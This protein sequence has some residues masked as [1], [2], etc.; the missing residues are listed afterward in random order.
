ME[1]DHPL[2][3]AFL[4]LISSDREKKQQ[5]RMCK[6]FQCY[7]QPCIF[8]WDLSSK[9]IAPCT[10]HNESSS[11]SLLPKKLWDPFPG[12]IGLITCLA[13]S[14]WKEAAEYAIHP[15]QTSCQLVFVLVGPWNL[16]GTSQG[17]PGL[18]TVCTFGLSPVGAGEPWGAGGCHGASGGQ[19][20]QSI[21]ISPDQTFKSFHTEPQINVW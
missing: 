3:F 5:H 6:S 10:L 21:N 12:L 15:A 4:L 13:L 9:T 2:F 18:S 14:G 19:P 8:K 16:S 7:V 11:W 17:R 20:D 1:M